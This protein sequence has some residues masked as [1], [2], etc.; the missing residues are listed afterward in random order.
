MDA[1]AFI[2]EMKTI[3]PALESLGYRLAVCKAY[4][5]PP[6][7]EV[8]VRLD[9]DADIKAAET[10]VTDKSVIASTIVD[11]AQSLRTLGSY[12]GFPVVGLDIGYSVPAMVKFVPFLGTEQ[13]GTP[14]A[15]ALTRQ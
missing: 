8:E 13:D 12:S 15:G 11:I 7:V 9:T 6:R 4:A 10:V 5:V 14:C 3:T 2:A 1:E